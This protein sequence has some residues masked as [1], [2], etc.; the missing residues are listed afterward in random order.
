MPYPCAELGYDPL[1]YALLTSSPSS[2]PQGSSITQCSYRL[3]SCARVSSSLSEDL[4]RS[5]LVCTLHPQFAH[6]AHVNY[7]LT[8]KT[9]TT[10]YGVGDGD[11]SQPSIDLDVPSPQAMSGLSL[12]YVFSN[13]CTIY[14]S[15][16]PCRP[17]QSA[18]P[19]WM[20]PSLQDKIGRR[21]TT[22]PLST[23]VKQ[24]SSSFRYLFLHSYHNSCSDH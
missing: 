20:L 16:P 14:L 1:S 10:P 11:D 6:K 2:R 4:V 12:L 9:F 18:R 7:V 17:Y 3:P 13:S 8:P 24:I 15:Q 5:A 21:E 23:S 19:R 22:S